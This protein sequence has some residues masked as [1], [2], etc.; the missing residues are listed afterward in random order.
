ML[1]PIVAVVSISVS[2]YDISHKLLTIL[3]ETKSFHLKAAK[4]KREIS[5]TFFR[6]ADRTL[7]LRKSIHGFEEVNELHS[8]R[9]EVVFV[10]W[11]I[12]RALTKPR[13]VGNQLRVGRRDNPILVPF[14]NACPT[15]LM[16]VG[17]RKGFWNDLWTRGGDSFPPPAPFPQEIK[18]NSIPL[19]YLIIRL[20]PQIWYHLVG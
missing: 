3:S 6:T 13:R 7:T 17:N 16:D 18:R 10:S 19:W 14:D 12:S 11:Q 8:L 5:P 9:L 15:E 4:K 2:K 20:R 1:I